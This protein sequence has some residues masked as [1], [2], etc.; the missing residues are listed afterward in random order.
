MPYRNYVRLTIRETDDIPWEL[1]KWI[2]LC[3][4]A[5]RNKLNPNW[6]GTLRKDQ[7]LYGR[8]YIAIDRRWHPFCIPYGLQLLPGGALRLVLWVNEERW[9]QAHSCD[10]FELTKW[11]QPTWDYPANDGDM[12]TWGH[13]PSWVCHTGNGV[14]LDRFVVAERLA[15]LLQS[16]MHSFRPLGTADE[17]AHLAVFRK[18]MTMDL[19]A[20]HSELLW[21]AGCK[22]E[23]LVPAF[24]VPVGLDDKQRNSLLAMAVAW[25]TKFRARGPLPNHVPVG[26]PRSLGCDWHAQCHV[27]L[28]FD[29]PAS[30]PI[31][32]GKWLAICEMHRNAQ[33]TERNYT[34]AR[35]CK[36]ELVQV[37]SSGSLRLIFSIWYERNLRRINCAEAPWIELC[38][39]PYGS[40][41]VASDQMR[42]WIDGIGEMGPELKAVDVVVSLAELLLTCLETIKTVGCTDRDT[43]RDCFAHDMKRMPPGSLAWPDQQP[44]F[45]TLN[46]SQVASILHLAEQWRAKMAETQSAMAVPSQPSLL[47]ERVKEIDAGEKLKREHAKA[48]EEAQKRVT[49]RIESLQHRLAEAKEETQ[50]CL[51]AYTNAYRDVH[52]TPPH[53]RSAAMLKAE[54]SASARLQRMRR[55]EQEIAE[56]LAKDTAPPPPPLPPPPLPPLPPLP[57]PL[58]PPSECVDARLPESNNHP[59]AVLQRPEVHH[60]PP[61]KPSARCPAPVATERMSFSCA[62]VDEVPTMVAKLMAVCASSK[63]GP[64]QVMPDFVQILDRGRVRVVMHVHRLVADEVKRVPDWAEPYP[65]K[66]GLPKAPILYA[67]K[68]PAWDESG[69]VAPLAHSVHLAALLHAWFE[70][71]SSVLKCWKKCHAFLKMV[72]DKDE[73]KQPT[74]TEEQQHI[75]LELSE[76]YLILLNNEWRNASTERTES[77]KNV[78]ATE[79]PKL[80][81][82]PDK[83]A[84]AGRTTYMQSMFAITKPAMRP[85]DLKQLSSVSYLSPYRKDK[86][87]LAGPNVAL[88]WGVHTGIPRRVAAW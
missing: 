8:P 67:A 43:L 45:R 5:H 77:P 32:L 44:T 16:I 66:D 29:T 53:Q 84:S 73:V 81:A 49:R 38:E 7:S 2:A 41:V 4:A 60:S 25:L 12:L 68:L 80:G 59:M 69:V 76:E 30:I 31:Q 6:H 78:E 87:W 65:A 19:D 15:V 22:H 46:D 36:P 11:V 24:L 37:L 23:K 62:S 10:G 47:K 56:Q 70:K 50:K 20:G 13:L 86:I 85:L 1:G 18:H 79:F 34:D 21:R 26:K 83:D 28:T 61:H 40:E 63:V 33:D 3:D 75:L 71:C 82:S 39:D 54:A 48:M 14:D 88:G 42:S 17:E 51:V 58:P 52:E 9:A 27:H 64:G 74:L 35:V 57:P 72:T 55:L